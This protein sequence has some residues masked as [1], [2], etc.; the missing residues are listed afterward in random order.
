MLGTARGKPWNPYVAGALAGLLLVASLYA[1][2]KYF[3]AST[4]FVR[5]AGMLEQTVA[6][7][8]VAQM[9]YFMK[10]M[11][12]VDWQWMFV[13]GI[14]L[15]SCVASLASGTFRIQAVPDRFAAR[16]GP[17]VLR[18]SGV[19]FAGGVV[20]MFGARLADGCPSGHGLSGTLQLAASGYVALVCFF[21]GGVV[22]ARLLYGKGR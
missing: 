19:A 2:G 9:P 14:V 12:K 6:A 1:S 10:E 22:V 13:V 7:E 5:A 4:T 3:G 17:S 8:R 11:P 20:A 18:R 21:L 15:G 16:F